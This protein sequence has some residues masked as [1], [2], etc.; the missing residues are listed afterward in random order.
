MSDGEQC[1]TLVG[2]DDYVTTAIFSPKDQL[3]LSASKDEKAVIWNF[4]TGEQLFNLIG[5][6]L[7]V[8]CAAFSSDGN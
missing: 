4:D 1:T 8:N 3:I 2:H 7:A 6:S 5:H